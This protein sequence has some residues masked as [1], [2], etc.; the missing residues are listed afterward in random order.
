MENILESI[1]T[2]Y[3][4]QKLY[5]EV[6]PSSKVEESSLAISFIGLRGGTL[7]I[8]FKILSRGL[9]FLFFFFLKKKK[10]T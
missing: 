8:S 3:L 4:S 1:C 2:F 7:D 6:S 5:A 10:K 9:L